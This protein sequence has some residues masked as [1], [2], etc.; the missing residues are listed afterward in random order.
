MD[1]IAIIAAALFLIIPLILSNI[2]KELK[3]RITH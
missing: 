2:E 3:V 1:I